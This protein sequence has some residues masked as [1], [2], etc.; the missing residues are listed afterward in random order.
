MAISSKMLL[1]LDGDHLG[2]EDCMMR[3]TKAISSKMLLFLDGDH[4]GKEDCLMRMT[5][6]ISSKMLLFLRL[7]LTSPLHG[8]E[9]RKDL[10]LA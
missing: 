6:A 5:K 4:L 3:M 10:F 9:P 8:L 1:F 2:K 7:L